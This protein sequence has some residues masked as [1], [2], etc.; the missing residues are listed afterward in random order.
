MENP[1]KNKLK[2]FNKKN[3]FFANLFYMQMSG[4]EPKSSE[5]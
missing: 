3:V 4:F 2:I 5:F 1:L